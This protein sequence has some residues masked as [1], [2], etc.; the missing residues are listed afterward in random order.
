[1]SEDNKHDTKKKNGEFKVPPRTYLLWIAILAAIP[2]LMFFKN[3]A[4]TQGEL[5]SQSQF[6]D[7]FTSSNIVRGVIVYDPQ[8]PYLRE[9][10]GKGPSFGA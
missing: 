3:S 6:I 2:L 4:G 1:M 10:H 7:K 8:S 9:I 5:L